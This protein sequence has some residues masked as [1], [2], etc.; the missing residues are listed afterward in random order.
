MTQR[1]RTPRRATSRRQRLHRTTRRRPRPPL[2]PRRHRPVCPNRAGRARAQV[3]DRR[4]AAPSPG[5]GKRGHRTCDPL[6]Q[7]LRAPRPFLMGVPQ[8]W[9]P[10]APR[11]A[12]PK[13]RTHPKH[14]SR[15]RGPGR[16]SLPTRPI[17][18]DRPSSLRQTGGPLRRLR[19]P[20]RHRP[21]PYCRSPRP[22]YRDR[23]KRVSGPRRAPRRPGT[24]PCRGGAGRKRHGRSRCP[25]RVSRP[26]PTGEASHNMQEVMVLIFLPSRG[27]RWPRQCLHRR[28]ARPPRLPHLCRR[29]LS[30]RS[31]GPRRCI[32]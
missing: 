3:N 24:L 19:L 25:L 20:L 13:R 32:P 9:R 15:P 14:P 16:P 18:R 27:S 4:T 5:L 23:A 6:Q 8:R 29:L 31:P 10:V 30:R 22:A 1:R 7:L 26:F 17:R 28:G 2:P 11:P 12:R 21:G